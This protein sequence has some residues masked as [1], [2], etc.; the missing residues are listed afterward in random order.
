MDI[1]RKLI[2]CIALLSIIALINSL[3]IK[4]FVVDP[5]IHYNNAIQHGTIHPITGA[6]EL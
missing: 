3:M 1:F 4:L 5:L 6:T 2:V